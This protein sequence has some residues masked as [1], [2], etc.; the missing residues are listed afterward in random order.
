MG[1]SKFGKSP[2]RQTVTM[3]KQ[4]S[5][6][7]IMKNVNNMTKSVNGVKKAGD[8][9]NNYLKSGGIYHAVIIRIRGTG[10]VRVRYRT[11]RNPGSPA[12]KGFP[13]YTDWK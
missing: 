3:G 2:L 6:E 9:L 10:Y 11:E 8:Y 1:E 7:W 5:D 13:V 4:M 12:N